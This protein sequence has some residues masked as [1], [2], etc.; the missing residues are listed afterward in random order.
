MK[1]FKAYF[2]TENSRDP[3]IITDK[4]ATWSALY[5]STSILIDALRGP[6]KDRFGYSPFNNCAKSK[7]IINTESLVNYNCLEV[8]D[9]KDFIDQLKILGVTK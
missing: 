4:D 8:N 3:V 2:N 6:Y 7:T 1:P 9:L 5:P